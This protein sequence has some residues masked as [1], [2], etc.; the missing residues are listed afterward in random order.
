M[1]MYMFKIDCILSIR[2]YQ[3][4]MKVTSGSLTHRTGDVNKQGARYFSE[5]LGYQ[6]VRAV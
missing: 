3:S 5:V 2:C 4:E 1:C 6:D